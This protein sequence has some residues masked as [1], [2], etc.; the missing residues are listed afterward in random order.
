MEINHNGGTGSPGYV[1]VAGHQGS[2]LFS[3]NNDSMRVP[4]NV[5]PL[6]AKDIYYK[7]PSIIKDVLLL[8]EGWLVG[9]AISDI[10]AGANPRDYDI[11]VQDREKFQL[12]NTYLKSNDSLTLSINS[13]GGLKYKNQNLFEI[14]IWCQDLDRFLT[15]AT[16]LNYLYK[17][18]GQ[19]LLNVEK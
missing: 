19:V 6:K 18:K 15:N 3:V 7:L 11:I 12:A 10:M 13:F 4:N 17:L 5:S 14:D 16:Q 1:T 8:S 2:V 9:G